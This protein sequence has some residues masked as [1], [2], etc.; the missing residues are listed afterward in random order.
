LLQEARPVY[1]SRPYKHLLTHQTI[2]C[3]FI[4]LQAPVDFP[5]PDKEF[6]FYSPDEVAELP[7]PVLISRFLDDQI[8]N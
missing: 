2:H 5:L 3:R 7:K 1:I 6:S 4:H 8:R